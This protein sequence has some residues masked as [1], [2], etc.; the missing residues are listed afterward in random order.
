[1][2][3]RH[4]D[5]RRNFRIAAAPTLSASSNVLGH[6]QKYQSDTLQL[7][8]AVVWQRRLSESVATRYGVC[9]DDR[10]GRYKIYPSVALEWQPHPDWEIDVGF[11]VSSVTYWIRDSLSTGFRAAPD[12]S[13]WHVMDRNFEAESRF[14]YEAYVIEWSFELEAGPH[15]RLVAGAGR[16]LRNRLDMTLQNGERLSVESTP[17]D[18]IRAEIRWQF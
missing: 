18:R 1:M 13:E 16:Q 17:V 6:P 2:H 12:G 10:F 3:W 7:S 4:G 11:P 15:L 14:V 5:P 8:L 9:G